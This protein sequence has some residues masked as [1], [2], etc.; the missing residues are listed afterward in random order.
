MPPHK[1]LL[2]I[3]NLQQGGA[4]RQILELMTRL[5][6]RFAPVL[7]VYHD[8]DHYRRYLP[9]G[10]PRHVLGVRD[11]G[12]AGLARLVRVIEEERPHILHSFR[13]KA[14]F[15]ARL[16]ALRVKV[17]VVLSSCRTRSINVKFLLAE[18]LLHWVS[19]RVLTNSL[20]VKRE[21]VARA[22]VPAEKIRVIDN[23]IDLARFAPPSED[24]RRAA[25]A[26][27]G[28]GDDEVAF[29][30]PGRISGQK[31]QLGLALA[32]GLLRRR[33]AL[34]PRLRILL[35]GRARDALVAAL[36]PR[37]LSLA[38]VS[39]RVRTLGTVPEADMPSLYHAADAL[40]LPSMYEGLPNAVIEGHA[41]GLPAVVS[42]AANVDGLV[43]PEQTGLEVPTGSVHGLADALARMAAL[44]AEERRAM[45]ARGRAHIESRF[46]AE[47]VL[48]ETVDLYDQLL[49]EKG[50]A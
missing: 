19:D 33:G 12:P 15:W 20:G 27:F 46:Q 28:L 35:A 21:L 16:A 41:C 24:E 10:Q 8:S 3:P 32:L 48:G 50:V 39:D 7:C 13:D 45:G 18:P 36:L 31:N 17:P 11:M 42:A 26:R 5:P 14:N 43:V 4:E 49:R 37:G 6:E 1:V 38:G 47:R 30:L 40:L 22:R 23:F 9:Q 2:F 25:R 44:P 29:V 34:P